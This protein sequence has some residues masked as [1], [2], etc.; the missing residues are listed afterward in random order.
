MEYIAIYSDENL[1][2]H[3]IKGQKWG[4]RRWQNAD[5]SYN[6][7]GK[8]RY[9]GESSKMAKAYA[10]AEK[11]RA[12]AEKNRIKSAKYAEKR[13]RLKARHFKTDISI[14][15][16]RS[17]DVKSTRARLRADRLERKAAKLEQRAVKWAQDNDH[18]STLMSNV[19]NSD[20]RVAEEFIRKN[21]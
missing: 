13:D 8:K 20:R 18:G 14:G 1:S 16:E 12:K 7:A 9:R 21:S 2:H 10:K 15:R 6:E 17:A 19:S 11:L 4:I 3:G 5:G